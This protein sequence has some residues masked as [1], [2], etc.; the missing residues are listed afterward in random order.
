[1]SFFKNKEKKGKMGHVWGL[2]PVGGGRI[3]RKAVRG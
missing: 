3:K 2:T 1:M